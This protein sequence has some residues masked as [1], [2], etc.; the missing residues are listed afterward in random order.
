MN[1]VLAALALEIAEKR[2]MIAQ[3][4]Q[5]LD[6]ANEQ[7]AELAPKPPEARTRSRKNPA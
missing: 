4:R 1:D 2:L 6:A 3:L 7:L 5:Q